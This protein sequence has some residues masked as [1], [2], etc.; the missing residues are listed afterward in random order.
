[1]SVIWLWFVLGLWFV[2]EFTGSSMTA[3]NLLKVI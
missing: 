3:E 1:M 2:V